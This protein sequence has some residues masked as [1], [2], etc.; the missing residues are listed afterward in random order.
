MLSASRGCKVAHPRPPSIAREAR[1][2][3][4]GAEQGS[5]NTQHRER[6]LWRLWT[7]LA[8]DTKALS[9][10]RPGLGSRV[11]QPE[12]PKQI[13]VVLTTKEKSKER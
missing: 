10:V 4:G 7:K 11:P 6:S 1:G 3:R 2:L 12:T 8:S 13:L 9:I 5:L